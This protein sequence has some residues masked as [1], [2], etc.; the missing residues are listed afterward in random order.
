MKRSKKILM[1][2]LK[3][4]LVIFLPIAIL[5]TVVQY[6]AFNKDFYLKEYSKYEVSESTGISNEDLGE[7]T[8]RLLDYLKQNEEDLNIRVLING[9]MEE[10]FGEREKLHMVDVK[11]LFIKGY[12]LKNTSIIMSIVSILGIIIFSNNKRKDIFQVI[13][14]ASGIPLI[15]MLTLFILIKTDFYKYF[16]YFHKIFFTNDLWLLNPKTDILIQLVPLG[17]F[18]DI[19]IKILILFSLILI[20]LIIISIYF[21]KSLRH[22]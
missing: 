15:L 22:N 11:E 12:I 8:N 5:L 19:S 21:S 2:I 10:V 4:I 3:A 1:N 9:S 7:I 16:T 17:F 14:W 6:Y 18:T 20:F 13:Y